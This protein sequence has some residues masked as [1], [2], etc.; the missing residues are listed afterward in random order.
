[1]QK[2]EYSFIQGLLKQPSRLHSVALKCREVGVLVGSSP[3]ACGL[4]VSR[5]PGCQFAAKP[6][7]GKIFRKRVSV[8]FTLPWVPQIFSY[9]LRA[10]FSHVSEIQF[11]LCSWDLYFCFF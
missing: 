8:K 1:M 2:V 9:K 4:N 11:E 7:T 5:A 3:I 10:V 6:V